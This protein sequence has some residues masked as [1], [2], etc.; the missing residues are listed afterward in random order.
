MEAKDRPFKGCLV[1]GRNVNVIY[2]TCPGCGNEVEVF[3]DES[4]VKCPRCG[5]EIEVEKCKQG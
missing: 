5:T 4:I 2:C 3:S 1:E